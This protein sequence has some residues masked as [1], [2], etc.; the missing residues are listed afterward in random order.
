[1]T[2][3]IVLFCVKQHGILHITT[4]NEWIKC[5]HQ[6]NPWS[7][8]IPFLRLKIYAQQLFQCPVLG[9]EFWTT[10]K[11][12]GIRLEFWWF[13]CL[14]KWGWWDICAVFTFRIYFTIHI[15]QY[16][17]LHFNKRRRQE[18]LLKNDWKDFIATPETKRRKN[19]VAVVYCNLFAKF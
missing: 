11:N 7:I 13:G 17:I 6:M 2:L 3:K 4:Q 18:H 5:V 15:L 10:P 8:S 9:S 16:R 12:R 19:T 1:M 14:S